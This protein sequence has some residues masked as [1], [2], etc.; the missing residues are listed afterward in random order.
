MAHNPCVFA[1]Y[2]RWL[3]EGGYAFRVQGESV[4]QY[5]PNGYSL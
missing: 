5:L 4:H 1:C 2:Y 3:H